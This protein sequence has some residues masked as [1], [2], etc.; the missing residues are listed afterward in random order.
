MAVD[1]ATATPDT[2]LFTDPVCGMKVP[3]DAPLQCEHDGETYR[4]CSAACLER[5]EAGPETYLEPSGPQSAAEVRGN[6][7]ATASPC[8]GEERAGQAQPHPRS[9]AE[10]TSYLCPMCPEV[11]EAAPGACPSCGM[12]LEPA[13]PSGPATR[14]EYTCPM[15]PE[16]VQDGPGTCPKCGMAL[17]P[18]TVTIDDAPDPELVDMS[19][20]FWVSAALALP[21]LVLAM[22]ADLAPGW[23]PA[24]LSMRTIQWVQLSLATPV[25]LWGGWP[26]LVRGWRS[27]Q[28][29][30]LNMFTLIG[31]GV[32]VAWGYS[33][34]ALLL[35]SLFPATMRMADGT[36]PVYFEAAAV[37][38]ALVLL[39]QVLE[40]RARG[41]TNQALRML[42]GLAPK[43]ARLVRDDGTE[44]DVPL[45]RSKPRTC[46]GFALARR[47]PW[48]A[49]WSPATVRWTSR[50]SPVSR[51]R[52]S[53]RTAIG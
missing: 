21:V 28:T 43:T 4:F 13:T 35:P 24:W 36:V 50:W 19:K 34:I 27:V 42:L 18:R 17:E 9:G 5:F 2:A 11:Q 44:V 6:H 52:W 45:T 7:A 1:S 22:V 8:R 30:N 41:S 38:T 16:V 33:L 25:V 32:S 23:L 10:G 20:R 12:A 53:N 14:T 37:I 31:L 3:E 26:L 40:L 51:C 48:T 46:C 39:G 47:C 29:W 49:S 15:H